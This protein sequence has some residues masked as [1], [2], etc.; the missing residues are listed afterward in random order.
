MLAASVLAASVFA[1]SVFAA[2]AF[3]AHSLHKSSI[4]TSLIYNIFRTQIHRRKTRGFMSKLNKHALNWMRE[5][6]TEL[7]FALLFALITLI[8]FAYD[9]ADSVTY[10]FAAKKH[11][12]AVFVLAFAAG[13]TLA[14][15]GF[16]AFAALSKRA[17]RRKDVSRKTLRLVFLIAL[18]ACIACWLVWIW[19][20]FPGCTT[21]DA[22]RQLQG[23]NHMIIWTNQHPIFTSI[24]MGSFMQLGFAIFKSSMGALATYM[25]PYF[26]FQSITCAY[27]TREV[28]RISKS[29]PAGAITCAFF[30]ILVQFGANAQTL[31]KDSLY[32][33]F[34]AWFFLF[35]CR[36]VLQGRSVQAS[37]ESKSEKFERGQSDKGENKDKLE[38]KPS[39]SAHKTKRSKRSISI[40]NFIGLAIFGIC[41]ALTRRESAYIVIICVAVLLIVRK[42]IRA[43]VGAALASILIVVLVWNKALVPSLGVEP[44]PKTDGI[45]WAIQQTARMLKYHPE[46]ISA[47]QKSALENYFDDFDTLA[48]IY[49]PKTSDPVRGKFKDDTPDEFMSTYY[50]IALA[51]PVRFIDSIAA[52]SYG[53]FYLGNFSCAWPTIITSK[54][55][56]L[57]SPYPYDFDSNT[58][59]V[60]SLLTNYVS[61]WQTTP[62][63]VQL[64]SPALYVWIALLCLFYFGGGSRARR[65]ANS[66]LKS[67]NLKYDRAFMRRASLI[68]L[69][70]ALSV[71]VA[72]ISPVNGYMRYLFGVLIATPL[73]I[74]WCAYVSPASP[75]S[76]SAK[77]ST[78]KHAPASPASSSNCEQAHV[79]TQA[80]TH[81][82]R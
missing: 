82:E 65:R 79:N 20:F 24:I 17:C 29:I 12:F 7:I 54:E 33:C 62:V 69:P 66:K 15:L 9:S 75:D 31:W 76:T 52:S 47:E 16:R 72:C 56:V 81:V 18:I 23:Y 57:E 58:E 14:L 68:V 77:S 60:R 67:V 10:I 38:Q 50:R 74:S 43:Y 78:T 71:A 63:L 46:E 27:I 6:M 30:C 37:I 48:Q 28:V 64:V 2:S 19:A 49:N 41:T 11:S 5:H 8:C 1:A 22:I 70:A 39:L 45:G 26:I 35:F 21:H 80:P 42:D 25:I 51:C 36:C 40:G 59:G 53:Y 44:A 4:I 13:L 55:E 32:M 61:T 34:F 73:L 3:N